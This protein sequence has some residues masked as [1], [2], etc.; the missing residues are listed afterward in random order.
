LHSRY[1]GS[2]TFLLFHDTLHMVSYY[3]VYFIDI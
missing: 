3:W 2:F 1:K